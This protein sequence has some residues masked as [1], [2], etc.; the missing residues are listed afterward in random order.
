[1][2]AAAL[3]FLALLAS[4]CNPLPDSRELRPDAQV[5]GSDFPDAKRPV[6]PIT[7]SRWSTEQARD[8]VDEAQIVMDVAGIVPGMTVADIGA[9][10]GYYTIRLAGRVGPSGRV[11]GQ[12]ITP[13]ALS[14]LGTRVE[15]ERHDNVSVVRGAP[16]DPHLPANSFDRVFLVHMYHEITAPYEFLWRL[17]PA[18]RVGGRV[19]VVDAERPT[20]QHG[21]PVALLDCEMRVTGYRRVDL[22][23][24]PQAGGYLAAYEASGNRPEPDQMTACPAQE[25]KED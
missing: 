9:G 11:V 24:L 14:A 23:Q 25:I 17:R 4:A 8:K 2:K 20:S 15:R 1:M 6:A 7:S 3:P 21:T 10:E 13:A 5:P 18:L 19:I 16:A 12:D 22:Q